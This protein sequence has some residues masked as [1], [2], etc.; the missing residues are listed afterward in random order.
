MTVCIV[1]VVLGRRRLDIAGGDVV[2]VCIVCVVLG[3]R[4]LDIAGGDV[5]TVCI[6]CVVLG[7]R[8]LDI[9]GGDVVTVCIICVV[10]GRRRL[11]IAGG[12]VVTVCMVFVIEDRSDGKITLGVKD[13]CEGNVENEMSYCKVFVLINGAVKEKV[14]EGNTED[15]EPKVNDEISINGVVVG[16]NDVC[17]FGKDGSEKSDSTVSD[18]AL[19]SPDVGNENADSREEADRNALPLDIELGI[20]TRGDDCPYTSVD[21]SGNTQHKFNV[22][23]VEEHRF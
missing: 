1:C 2:T 15:C 7:R 18:I 5:V 6:V 14:S 23:I 17:E 12:D 10:L 16:I 4:R 21:S 11:D 9:A 3:R 8:M 20:K 22:C 13:T 19:V